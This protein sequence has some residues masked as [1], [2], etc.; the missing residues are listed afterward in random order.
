MQSF[1]LDWH[2]IQKVKRTFKGVTYSAEETL[3]QKKRPHPKLREAIV[4]EVV[5]QVRSKVAMPTRETFVPIH[6]VMVHKYPKSF[7]ETLGKGAECSGGLLFQLKPRF[8]N[9]KRCDR[10]TQSVNPDDMK[11]QYEQPRG[12]F[13]YECVRWRVQDFPDAV[14]ENLTK[15][16]KEKLQKMHSEIRPECWNVV[17]IKDLMAKTYKAQRDLINKNIEI[18][19]AEE[20]RKRARKRTHQ[21]ANTSGQETAEERVTVLMVFQEWPFLFTYDGLLQHFGELTQVDLEVQLTKFIEQETEAHIKF[22]ETLDDEFYVSTLKDMKKAT[23][24]HP[25]EAKENELRAIIIML[26]NYLSEESFIEI[27]EVSSKLLPLR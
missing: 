3:R 15:E 23:R 13:A 16:M 14:T 26:V 27:V 24:K 1:T 8:D 11:R 21:E 10:N 5:D 20:K 17:E 9:T 2:A 6:A 12:K 4:A 22:F 7:Q 18:A 19:L 25:D